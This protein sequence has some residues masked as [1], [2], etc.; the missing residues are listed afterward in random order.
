MLLSSL[1]TDTLCSLYLL[2]V[3][4]VCYLK[5]NAV[6]QKCLPPLVLPAVCSQHSSLPSEDTDYTRVNPAVLALHY[7]PRWH[8]KWS[9]NCVIER[10]QFLSRGHVVT[11]SLQRKWASVFPVSSLFTPPFFIPLRL[12]LVADRCLVRAVRLVLLV[13]S[14]IFLRKVSLFEHVAH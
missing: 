12:F 14:V 1:W 8:A 10:M 7:G 2:S 11:N 5:V 4:S 9:L 6:F 13:V 3:L